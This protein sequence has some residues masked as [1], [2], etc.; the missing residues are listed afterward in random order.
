MF[1]Y[2]DVYEPSI[3][4]SYFHRMSIAFFQ[5]WPLHWLFDIHITDLLSA[6]I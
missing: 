3:L 6:T 5:I 1:M 4:K 2:C